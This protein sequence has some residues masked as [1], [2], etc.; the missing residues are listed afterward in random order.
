M[1]CYDSM[2][3]LDLHRLHTDQ[4]LFDLRRLHAVN[5]ILF[6]QF[7]IYT[8]HCYGSSCSLCVERWPLTPVSRTLTHSS[9]HG[10]VQTVKVHTT[11]HCGHAVDRRCCVWTVPSDVT[12][13]KVDYGDWGLTTGHTTG[14]T[15]GFSFSVAAILNTADQRG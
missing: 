12:T 10:E 11:G 9:V 14:Q 13:P 4:K 5:V 6:M 8:D 7:K 15:Q 2:F 1:H 3:V